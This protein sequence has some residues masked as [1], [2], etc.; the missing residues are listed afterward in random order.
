MSSIAPPRAID[1]PSRSARRPGPNITDE[2][3][4]GQRRDIAD[5]TLATGSRL[6]NECERAR[7]LGVSQPTIRKAN[8][9]LLATAP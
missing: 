7:H 1:A 8:R 5:R 2:I 3:V 4:E 9:A 6:P